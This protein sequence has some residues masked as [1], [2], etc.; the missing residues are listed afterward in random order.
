MNNYVV[1]EIQLTKLLCGQYLR[2]SAVGTCGNNNWFF[3]FSYQIVSL[4]LVIQLE[5]GYGYT[6]QLT[7]LC[8]TILP[9][10]I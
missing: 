4:S 7:L 2:Y 10:K 6:E 3:I 1:C 8:F 5:I 9:S